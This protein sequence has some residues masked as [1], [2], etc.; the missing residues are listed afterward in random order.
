MV[1]RNTP[2]DHPAFCTPLKRDIL[3][4]FDQLPPEHQTRVAAVLL[5]R[6]FEDRQQALCESA[7]ESLMPANMGGPHQADGAE[8]GVE[9]W[10]EE[11]LTLVVEHMINHFVQDVIWDDLAFVTR[12]DLV[13]KGAV[14]SQLGSNP[15]QHG[16]CP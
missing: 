12:K 6:L 10:G 5:H 16:E 3:D 1:E 14:G 13:E 4:R 11:D 9:Q 8:A 7:I 2:S 15:K